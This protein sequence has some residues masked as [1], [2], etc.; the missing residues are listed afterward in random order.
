MLKLRTNR[1]S[2]QD[3]I[4]GPT[5]SETE[6]KMDSL[7][8]KNGHGSL[9]PL[10]QDLTKSATE[11]QLPVSSA[12]LN[13]DNRA[14]L[15][16]L[17]PM[18]A[19]AVRAPDGVI[20]WFN[21]RATELWGRVPQIGDTDE[22][23]CGAY[24]LYHPDGTYMA[25]CDTPVALALSSG[26]STHEEEVV[27]EKSDGTRVSVCV[28]IDPIRDG[29]G[30]IIGAVNFFHDITERKQ[31]E[32]EREQL[33]EE[34]KIHA[35]E[36]QEARGQLEL[37][38]E[39][40]TASLRA[41]SSQLMHL[42]DDERRRISRDL[43]DSI[44][45]HLALAKMSLQ[46]FANSL[47]KGDA[48]S[49]QILRE[50][51][52]IF[53]TAARETR[54]VSYLL[55]PP[56]LDEVGLAAAVS[57]YAEGYTKRSGVCL[58]VEIP[59]DLP[60]L[61]IDKETTLFRIVQES[62]TNVHRHSGASKAMIRITV[63]DDSLRLE[64]C[65]NGKGIVNPHSSDLSKRTINPGVGILGM[66]ERLRDLDGRLEITAENGTRVIA[67]IPLTIPLANAAAG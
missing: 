1:Q 25:H 63:K 24:K 39:Q 3:S 64:V 45:Q 47:P 51:E 11:T 42:Q 41:L 14:Y 46:A 49:Q 56:L 37:K 55:H 21:P 19:Y 59:E 58:E 18:A 4:L 6:R 54:T 9:T 27:I 5:V 2:P 66:R 28:H 23:F 61:T 13:L 67:T 35:A 33:F 36:L 53:D 7:N 30:E 31:K 34:V 12:V 57:W 20:A 38:V 43:H 17:L 10:D 40:R 50:T 65:D 15:M 16:D 26:V 52:E 60:R 32:A 44:G 8:T 48:N 62:L 29:N 22:R